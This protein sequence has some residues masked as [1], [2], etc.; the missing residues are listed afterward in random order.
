MEY[1]RRY[2]RFFSGISCILFLFMYQIKWKLGKPQREKTCIQFLLLN[3]KAPNAIRTTRRGTEYGGHACN[4]PKGHDGKSPGLSCLILC[5]CWGTCVVNVGFSFRWAL[6]APGAGKTMN[7]QMFFLHP[8]EQK[9]NSATGYCWYWW[10]VVLLWMTEQ[11]LNAHQFP[12]VKLRANRN[13]HVQVLH[14]LCN[15]ASLLSG[16]NLEDPTLGLRTV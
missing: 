5:R 1:C 4:T 9:L 12:L 13:L 16:F 14:C 6:R 8:C 2:G 3:G 11:R 10:Y 7:M 15:A